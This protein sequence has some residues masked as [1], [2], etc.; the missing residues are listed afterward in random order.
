VRL[1]GPRVIEAGASASI[2]YASAPKAK[3][4]AAAR[5]AARAGLVINENKRE[6]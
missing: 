5:A 3:S 4:A 6:F 1:E 2:I